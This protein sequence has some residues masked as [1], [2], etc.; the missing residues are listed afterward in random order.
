MEEKDIANRILTDKLPSSVI[1]YDISY[2]GHSK[3]IKILVNTIGDKNCRI[4]IFTLR[5]NVT[6]YIQI[7]HWMKLIVNVIVMHHAIASSVLNTNIPITMPDTFNKV[8]NTQQMNKLLVSL[9]A[10]KIDPDVDN[11]IC[12]PTDIDNIWNTGTE[13]IH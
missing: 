1:L 7:Y 3:S 13:G 8:E 9:A 11:I 4:K 5:F 10:W 2:I 6:L 12:I